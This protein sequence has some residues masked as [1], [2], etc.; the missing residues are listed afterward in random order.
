M[1]PLFEALCFVL[2]G[3]L[4]LTAVLGLWFSAFLP[5]LG[6]WD[7]R[8]FLSFFTVQLASV[9]GYLTELFI[10][11]NPALADVERVLCFGDSLLPSIS[12]VM[13]V[14][15]LLH[16]CGESWRKSL[17]F[18]FV[19]ACWAM[20]FLLLCSTCFGPWVY[21][22]TSD[23]EFI[24]GSW[25]PLSMLPLIAISVLTLVALVRRRPKLSR[26]RYTSMIALV[27]PLLLA[28]IIH[29]FIDVIL[30]I[31]ICMIGMA[32]VM[33]VS[34]VWE[35]ANLYLRQRDE[36]AHQRANIMVLQMRPHFIYNTMTSIYY[37][38]AQ[39]PQKAQQVTLDFTSYLR[40]NFTAV[41][42]EQ[43]VPFPEELEHA[44]AYLAVEQAQHEDD[45]CVAFDTPHTRFRLPP[46][47]LQPI[48][49][50]SVKHGLDPDAG[51]LHITIRTRETEAGSVILVEDDGA[52]FDAV[53]SS[54]PHVALKNIQGRL[55]MMCGGTL[56]VLLRVEGG[57]VVR[58]TIPNE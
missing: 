26:A 45:L 32:I 33:F 24:R 19:A 4:L 14:V 40:K 10:Y 42:S 30:L 37:L 43:P 28:E 25:F 29:A 38:C 57:T 5:G 49:E 50:N 31:N 6:D 47:T 23:G 21:Y 53:T 8:F 20:Y 12:I 52:G 15:Y 13:A 22:I 41:A 7:R 46:L 17:L 1:I 44:R 27:V 54:S 39:D 11:G 55:E 2:S 16:C 48:V 9:G 56:E 36:I 58:V 3:A 18:R 35:Q 34:V 51:P